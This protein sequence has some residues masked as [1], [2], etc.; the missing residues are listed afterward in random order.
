MFIT[1]ANQTFIY[2]HN[3]DGADT[4]CPFSGPLDFTYHLIGRRECKVPQSEVAQC[5]QESQLMFSFQSC[6]ED[7]HTIS[8]GNMHSF[9]W[10]N[11][12][13][14]LEKICKL[15]KYV[16][17]PHCIMYSMTPIESYIHLH[18]KKYTLL[19]SQC[20]EICRWQWGVWCMQ[21]VILS[22]SCVNII[23]WAYFW[24]LN[25]RDNDL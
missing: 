8:K 17:F 2:L 6:P 16:H 1:S 24:S 7:Y 19:H 12:A 11:Y 21:Q 18:A 9:I 14:I 22:S 5:V 3:L 25:R 4:Q 20:T 10:F 15:N 13:H 23:F